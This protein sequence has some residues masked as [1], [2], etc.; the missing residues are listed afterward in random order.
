MHHIPH[1][2]NPK[3]ISEARPEK[4]P[5]SHQKKNEVRPNVA[6][7]K[8]KQVSSRKRI[9][10]HEEEP[11]D[12]IQEERTEEQGEE[13]EG[14]GEGQQSA[15]PNKEPHIGEGKDDKENE[16]K[17]NA[18]SKAHPVKAEIPRSANELSRPFHLPLLKFLTQG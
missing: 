5:T 17:K 10:R 14:F 2:N 12:K 3:M 8:P 11:L 4:I 15:T 1:K 7:P 13:D 9:S 18:E 6:K 16:N